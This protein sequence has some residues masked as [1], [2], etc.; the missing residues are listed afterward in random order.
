VPPGGRIIEMPASKKL[1]FRRHRDATYC[2]ARGKHDILFND[3]RA[4]LEN[5]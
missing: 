2:G 3:I 4:S 1:P 5:V